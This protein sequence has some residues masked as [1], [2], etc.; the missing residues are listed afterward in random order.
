MGAPVITRVALVPPVGDAGDEVAVAVEWTGMPNIAEISYQWR[1]GGRDIAGE[2][3][4]QAVAPESYASFYCEVQVDNGDG[5]AIGAS[6]YF[7]APPVII[8]PDPGPD[9]DPDP[10]TGPIAHTTGFSGGFR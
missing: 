4:Q 8:P 9:P 6:P 2:V 10:G 3:G 7:A 5:V 1:R